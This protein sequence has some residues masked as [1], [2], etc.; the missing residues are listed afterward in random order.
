MKWVGGKMGW[1]QKVAVPKILCEVNAQ[2]FKY[3]TVNQELLPAEQTINAVYYTDVQE[4]P[5]KRKV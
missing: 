3:S 1:N 2:F 4:R 5:V